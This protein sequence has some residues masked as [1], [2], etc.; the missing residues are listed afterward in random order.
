VIRKCPPEPDRRKFVLS[1]ELTWE[2]GNDI[3]TIELTSQFE[4]GTDNIK[5]CQNP[6]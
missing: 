2:G 4:K 6:I 3:Q 5:K 1:E